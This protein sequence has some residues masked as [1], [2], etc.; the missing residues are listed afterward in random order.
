[1]KNIVTV[2][3]VGIVAIL[4]APTLAGAHER[5]V[6]EIGGAYYQFV[7]GSQSEPVVVDDKSGLDFRVQKLA[8]VTATSGVPVGGLEKTLKFEVSAEGQ[9]RTQDITG[10]YGQLGSYNSLFYP[11]MATVLTYRI[12]GTVGDASVDLSFTC[13]KGGH[14]MGGVPD[15]VSKDMGGGVT[16]HLQAGMFSCPTE[17]AELGFPARSASIAT[18]DARLSFV[19]RTVN[20]VAREFGFVEIALGLLVVAFAAV[21]LQRKKKTV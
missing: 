9:K 17:K 19:E 1:M 20:R 14:V 8:S 4:F 15:T 11:T 12:F 16:R 7:I 21:A 3:T 18:L 6:F 10:V 5:G 13:H 2:L